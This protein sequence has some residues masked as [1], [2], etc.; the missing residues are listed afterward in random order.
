MSFFNSALVLRSPIRDLI[1]LR[2]VY[3]LSSSVFEI[4]FRYVCSIWILNLTRSSLDLLQVLRVSAWGMPAVERPFKTSTS[5]IGSLPRS[6]VVWTQPI[7][8]ATSW[9]QRPDSLRA[10]LSAPISAHNWRWNWIIGFIIESYSSSLLIV[11]L[12][13]GL[14]LRSISVMAVTKIGN[15]FDIW[16]LVVLHIKRLLMIASECFGI[17]FT[18]LL[19]HELIIL[20]L[21]PLVRKLIRCVFRRGRVLILWFHNVLSSIIWL[22]LWEN[23]NRW[24]ALVR[25]ISYFQMAS[26]VR[27]FKMII[28]IR[29][30]F[31]VPKSWLWLTQG[32]IYL[33]GCRRLWS[34]HPLPIT[35]TFFVLAGQLVPADWNS[36]REC[37]LLIFNKPFLHIISILMVTS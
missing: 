14:I 33:L 34:I 2:R 32:K 37:P 18:D 19:I 24:L 22:S 9:P 20:V 21:V 1:F 16:M 25:N 6:W 27:L 36:F 12:S 13:I 17:R 11:G 8:F 7:L 26:R 31:R 28:W 35:R 30:L 29:S 23:I 15:I 10:W 4:R 5:L 3:T